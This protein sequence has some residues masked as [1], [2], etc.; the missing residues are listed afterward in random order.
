MEVVNC[1]RDVFV[2]STKDKLVRI[3]NY[4]IVKRKRAVQKFLKKDVPKERL[5]D[6]SLEATKFNEKR[7]NY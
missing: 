7:Q 2:E 3:S 6:A 1:N 4:D 5:E